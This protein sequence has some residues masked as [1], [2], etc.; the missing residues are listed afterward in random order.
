M[1]SLGYG[2]MSIILKPMKGVL[3]MTL[4]ISE[5]IKKTALYSF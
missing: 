1:M 3:Q 5:G 2:I 4:K